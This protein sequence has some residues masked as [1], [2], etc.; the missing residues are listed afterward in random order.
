[1][2]LRF[3]PQVEMLDRRDVPSTVLVDDVSYPLTGAGGTATVTVSVTTEGDGYFHWNYLLHNDSFVYGQDDYWGIGVFRVPVQDTLITDK[4]SSVAA[5][6]SVNDGTVTWAFGGETNPGL[7][8]GQEANFWFTTPD[9]PIGAAGVEGL[10]PGFAGGVAG[11][12]LAP[13]GLTSITLDFS[14]ALTG[15][16][17]RIRIRLYEGSPLT[18]PP[19]IDVLVP[20]AAG[21]T[22]QQIRDNVATKV[23]QAGFQTTS[24]GATQLQIKQRIS[25]GKSA[26]YFEFFNWDPTLDQPWSFDKGPK[27]IQRGGVPTVTINGHE[28]TPGN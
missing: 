5:S 6:A 21:D 17:Y 19:L 24:N 9:V 10:E 2:S 14:T 22:A 15:E 26:G 1:M 23:Q 20:V 27:L 7:K 25:D 28:V 18:T 13:K 3:R 16:A 4:G 12:A 8:P 11:E